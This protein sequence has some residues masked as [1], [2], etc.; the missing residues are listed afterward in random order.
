MPSRTSFLDLPLEIRLRVYRCLFPPVELTI[1]SEKRTRPNGDKELIC[2]SSLVDCSGQLLMTCRTVL[3]EVRPILMEWTLVSFTRHIGAFHCHTRC[4]GVEAHPRTQYIRRLA[5]DID[6]EHAFELE[7]YSNTIPDLLMIEFLEITCQNVDWQLPYLA[8]VIPR[9]DPTQYDA[10]HKQILQAAVHLLIG[11][12]LDTLED[13][14][15]N[16]VKIIL[17]LARTKASSNDTAVSPWY[18]TI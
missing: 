3:V 14:S 12:R 16:G 11:T 17:Q 7:A 6:V 8:Q 9:K 15:K 18:P 1:D 4:A 13:K 10:I 2:F 5:I